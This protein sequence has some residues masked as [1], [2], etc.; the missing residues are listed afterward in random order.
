MKKIV[1]ENEKYKHISMETAEVIGEMANV[2]MPKEDEKGEYNV[3]KAIMEIREEG[4]EE[5]RLLL[6]V[7]MVQDGEITLE[8]AAK[9][10]DISVEEFQKK[11]NRK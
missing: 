10:L 8:T 3:C 5:G 7:S 4:R 6:L 9:R 1:S 2:G 11:M